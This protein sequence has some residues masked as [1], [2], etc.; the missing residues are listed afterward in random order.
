MIWVIYLTTYSMLAICSGA[1]CYHY[2]SQQNRICG[3]V[4]GTAAVAYGALAA[5]YVV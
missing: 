4:Y 3:A 5:T 1:L 2:Y